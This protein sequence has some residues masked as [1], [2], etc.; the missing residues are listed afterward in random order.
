M[1]TPMS[2]RLVGGSP[3]F[4]YFTLFFLASLQYSPAHIPI[5][6][7]PCSHMSSPALAPLIPMN[8]PQ[9][10]SLPHSWP[11]SPPKCWRS[12]GGALPSNERQ[13][14]STQPLLGCARRVGRCSW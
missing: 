5:P 4:A 14:T 12:V 3:N 2:S 10:H 8:V 1:R 13:L 7:V 11:L 6:K 9:T